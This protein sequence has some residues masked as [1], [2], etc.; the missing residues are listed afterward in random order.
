M[1]LQK[2]SKKNTLDILNFQEE[3]EKFEKDNDHHLY[4]LRQSIDDSII[5]VQHLISFLFG[6]AL[7]DPKVMEE[8]RNINRQLREM[9]CSSNL[10][11]EV[12]YRKMKK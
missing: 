7:D 10:I 4:I 3:K 9:T 11:C 5:E 12:T 1:E 8:I 6:E 2:E